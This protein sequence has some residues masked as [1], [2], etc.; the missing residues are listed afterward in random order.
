MKF[1]FKALVTV[2]AWTTVEADTYEEARK[3]AEDREVAC[4]TSNAL[5]PSE[6]EAW[7]FDNDGLPQGVRLEVE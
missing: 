1:E 6:E 2:S 5:Y 3:I 7:H 4:M